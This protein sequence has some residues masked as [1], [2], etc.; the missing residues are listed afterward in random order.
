[1]VQKLSTQLQNLKS[2]E[3]EIDWRNEDDE[4]V[5]LCLLPCYFSQ[6]TNFYNAAVYVDEKTKRG[7][8]S[9]AKKSSCQRQY[10]STIDNLTGWPK[11][12]AIGEDVELCGGR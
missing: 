3:G 8:F 9:R 4:K 7:N 2:N 10:R 1:M 6:Q 5:S 12:G 11:P